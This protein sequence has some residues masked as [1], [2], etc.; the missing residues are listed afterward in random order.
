MENAE[1]DSRELKAKRWRIKK[2][3][4]EEWASNVKG[5]KTIREP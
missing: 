3:N 2:N 5:A 4:R 1:N